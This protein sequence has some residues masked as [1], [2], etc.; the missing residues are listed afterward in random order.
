MHNTFTKAYSST[1]LWRFKWIIRREGYIE[2]IYSTLIR[3]SCKKQEDI[4]SVKHQEFF[5]ESKQKNNYLSIIQKSSRSIQSN[6][7]TQ[8]HVNPINKPSAQNCYPEHIQNCHGIQ[9]STCSSTQFAK[10]NV[11]ITNFKRNQAINTATS[12]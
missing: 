7:K 10:T 9:R 3:C 1:Y 11:F 4:Q 12:T 8:I 5:S 6:L 2:K